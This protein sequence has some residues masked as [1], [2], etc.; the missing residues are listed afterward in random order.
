MAGIDSNMVTE[1]SIICEESLD[2]EPS[3][4]VESIGDDVL[5]AGLSKDSHENA[6]LAA[7]F[8]ESVWP[9]LESNGWEKKVRL[10]QNL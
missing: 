2:P 5:T 9:K 3:V 6:R 1:E 4:L 7:A 8:W 10:H